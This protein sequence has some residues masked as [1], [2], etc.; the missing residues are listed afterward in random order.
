MLT[1]WDKLRDMEE[2]EM[3]FD[4]KEKEKSFNEYPE[5]YKERDIRVILRNKR[6]RKTKKLPIDFEERVYK[7]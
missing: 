1:K 4:D 6:N 7:P 2:S 5:V 3:P